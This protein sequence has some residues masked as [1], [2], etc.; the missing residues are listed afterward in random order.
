MC[1]NVVLAAFELLWFGGLCFH[2]AELSEF[3][4]INIQ[5]ECH[6]NIIVDRLQGCG[7]TAKSCGKVSHHHHHQ[8]ICHKSR[9]SKVIWQVHRAVSVVK[10]L[11]HE[12]QLN[13]THGHRW[14]RVRCEEHRAWPTL[15]VTNAARLVELGSEVMRR[16]VVLTSVSKNCQPEGDALRHSQPMQF[17]E[18][19]WHVIELPMSV[20]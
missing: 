11:E 18:Q 14:S 6:S 12:L 2:E 8:F 17:L 16:H 1:S 15:P 9:S 5:N 4:I 3:I 10:M 19:R 20:N 13:W 7:A